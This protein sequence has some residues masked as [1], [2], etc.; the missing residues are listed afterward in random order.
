MKRSLFPIIVL[1]ITSLTAAAQAHVRLIA[2][3]GG[4]ELQVG[5][6]FTIE[7]TIVIG[8]NLQNWDLWYS[9]TGVGGPWIPIATNLPPGSGAV[10]SIHTYDWTVPDA[11]SDQVRIRVRMDNSG[12]DYE[13]RSD[14]DFSIVPASCYADCNDDGIVNT[15]DFLCF[16]NLFNIGDPLADCNGD[17][18]I[19]TLDFLC[20]LNAYNEGC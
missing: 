3:N 15:L 8:H 4:E 1:A 5:S 18:I 20:F 2:P 12:T 14:N 16:L 11:V 9:T 7:W 10:G 13:D 17:G 19:N 6:V